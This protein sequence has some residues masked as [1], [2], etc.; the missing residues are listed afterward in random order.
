MSQ[1][2]ER[3]ARARPKFANLRA[4]VSSF[5]R[6]VEQQDIAEKLGLSP[7]QLSGYLGGTIP[8]RDTALRLYREHSIDLE[9]LLDPPS[10]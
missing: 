7:S 3:K 10:A 4:Y 2:T 1:R 9:G 6:E 8:G 5:P